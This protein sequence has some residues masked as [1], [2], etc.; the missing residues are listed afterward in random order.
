M[1]KP[2]WRKFGGETQPIAAERDAASVQ[3]Q[4]FLVELGYGHWFSLMMRTTPNDCYTED[5]SLLG[6]KSSGFLPSMRFTDFFH[7]GEPVPETEGFLW[8][9]PTK[10]TFRR[11]TNNKNN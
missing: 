10:P 3:L 8:C 7:Q 4:V 11:F 9:A 2:R 1:L 5:L 6:N